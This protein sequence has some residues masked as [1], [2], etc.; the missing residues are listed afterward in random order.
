[1]HHR[2]GHH[3]D[4]PVPA[5]QSVIRRRRGSIATR[6]PTAGSPIPR[7][8]RRTARIRPGGSRRSWRA[9]AA[10]P[11][12]RRPQAVE[13]L[14]VVLTRRGLVG[15]PDEQQPDH[16]EA[17]IAEVVQVGVVPAGREG[18]DLGVAGQ[19]DAA[20]DHHPPAIV[21]E[22]SAADP[23]PVRVGGRRYRR[24]QGDAGRHGRVPNGWRRGPA[25]PLAHGRYAGPRR[26]R[27][28]PLGRDTVRRADTDDFYC[29]PDADG[30]IVRIG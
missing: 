13:I 27:D 30:G 14:V 18:R 4:Q 1:M 15:L 16:V 26:R 24:R 17:E 2:V 29:N 6:A 12:R 19:I 10:G 28:R 8:A 22:V 9:R 3:P 5:G 7:R 11:P 25:G 23:E 21:H 20:E